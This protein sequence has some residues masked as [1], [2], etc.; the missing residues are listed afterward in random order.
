MGAADFL[1]FIRN[2]EAGIKEKGMFEGRGVA[3]ILLLVLLGG[4][5]AVAKYDQLAMSL[6]G[7]VFSDDNTAACESDDPSASPSASHSASPAIAA[8]RSD[9]GSI[10][11]FA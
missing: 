5:V 8:S 2:A 3:A 4:H 9:S 11:A 10:S 1:Q 7:C 6:V